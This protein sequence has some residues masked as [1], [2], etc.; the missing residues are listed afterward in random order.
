M[1]TLSRP[2]ERSTLDHGMARHNVYLDVGE[3]RAFV[4]HLPASRENRRDCAVLLCP[5]F[6]WEELASHRALRVWAQGLAG[7]GYPTARVTYPGTGDSSG[8]PG[9]P[10]RLNAWVA[11]V[12]TAAAWLREREGVDSVVGVGVGFGGLV[13]HLAAARGATLDG[14]VLW[15]TPRR[16]REFLRQL[17]AFSRLEMSEAFAGLPEPPPLPDGALEAGGFLLSAETTAA[18]GA[19]DL[20]TEPID[21]EL[22]LGVLL[23]GRDER[24]PDE[25]LRLALAE[26]AVAVTSAPGPGYAA[27]TSH[28]QDAVPSPDVAALVLKWLDERSGPATTEPR[29]ADEPVPGENG[30]LALGDGAHVVVERPIAF[31]AAG[32]ELTGVLVRPETDGEAHPAPLC[33]L[34]VNAGAIHRIGPNRM[35]VETARRWAALGIPSLRLDIEGVGESGGPDRGYGD[36]AHLHDLGLVEQLAGTLDELQRRGVAERFVL[37][38]MCSGAYQ[39]L[40]LALGDARVVAL[41]LLNPAVIEWDESVAPTRSLRAISLRSFANLRHAGTRARLRTTLR[42]VARRLRARLSSLPRSETGALPLAARVESKLERLRT[43]GVQ[44]LML[45]AAREPLD[46]EL[47]RLGLIDELRASPN[48]TVTRLAVASHTLRPQ[49]AQEQTRGILDGALAQALGTPDVPPT[50]RMGRKPQSAAGQSRTTPSFVPPK[51]TG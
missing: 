43:S 11:S 39:S 46:R 2:I 34:F 14:A 5:P 7:A 20:T 49:W 51:N 1:T 3:E 35:Y 40:H 13:A 30:E 41:Q 9:D 29:H 23:L 31:G 45:F 32:T 6:G 10:G 47:E 18:L 19:V 24:A 42:W 22:R 4:A 8:D 33:A 21:H 25:G 12:Q 27:I 50:S 15:A 16:G 48:V 17:R 37:I 44:V 38:G 28:P 36:T 26:R